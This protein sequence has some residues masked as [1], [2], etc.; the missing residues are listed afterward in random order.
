MLILIIF[1]L[2]FAGLVVHNGAVL[3]ISKLLEQ[4]R[5]SEKTRED[6]EVQLVDL[7]RENTDLQ[8]NQSRA[9]D[10][11]KEQS[12]DIKSCTRKLID[13]EQ[14][15]REITVSI[16]KR[17]EAKADIYIMKFFLQKKSNEYFSTLSSVY[18][19]VS[20]VIHR[21]EAKRSSS[22]TSSRRGR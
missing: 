13:A 6:T 9:N 3:D 16:K 1:I 10:K 5:R 18:D 2:I 7:R 20:V 8:R 19:R 12:A 11:I 22:I 4:I 15:L 21:T 14:N 17:G